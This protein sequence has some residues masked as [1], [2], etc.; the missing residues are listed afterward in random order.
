MSGKD[1][2]EALVAISNLNQTDSL[3]SAQHVWK[4]KYPVLKISN[5]LIHYNCIWCQK[6]QVRAYLN[7]RTTKAGEISKS[8]WTIVYDKWYA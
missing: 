8:K 4:P 1:P 2:I 6:V 3:N 5:K 7:Y